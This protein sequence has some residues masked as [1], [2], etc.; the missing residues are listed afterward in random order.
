MKI[1]KSV[2]PSLNVTDY[3]APFLFVSFMC[4]LKV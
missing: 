2:E 1:M 4:G 3:L